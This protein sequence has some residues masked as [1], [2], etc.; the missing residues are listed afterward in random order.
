MGVIYN[1]IVI[2]YADRYSRGKQLQ[3][4]NREWTTTIE[5]MN[6]DGFILPPFL[7][8]QNINHV[9]GTR[10]CTW[11]VRAP[12]NNCTISPTDKWISRREAR[13]VGTCTEGAGAVPLR[14]ALIPGGRPPPRLIHHLSTKLFRPPVAHNNW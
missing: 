6:N 9:V 13:T 4:G 3:P 11:F 8:L 10:G 12:S 1:N 14:P 2:I 7:I 5:Y